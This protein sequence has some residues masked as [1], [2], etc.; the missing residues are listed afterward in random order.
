M[1]IVSS[2][3]IL[4]LTLG[5]TSEPS[6]SKYI[7]STNTPLDLSVASKVR[8]PNLSTSGKS[9]K[10]MY[11]VLDFIVVRNFMFCA[12]FPLIAPRNNYVLD[13]R[14]GGIYSNFRRYLWN[15]QLFIESLV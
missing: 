14:T 12:I 6:S 1:V 2:I 5:S 4:L 3:G 9:L 15:S 7:S 10:S 8:F 11:C 13:I